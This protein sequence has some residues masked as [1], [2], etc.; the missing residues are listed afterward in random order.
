MFGSNVYIENE[1]VEC[2]G[3]TNVCHIDHHIRNIHSR[4]VHDIDLDIQNGPKL[5]I[6]IPIES[7]HATSYVL[8]IAIF[9]PSVAVL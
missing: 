2:S 3:I 1:R 5:N 4:N 8:A 7:P 6:N 9:A